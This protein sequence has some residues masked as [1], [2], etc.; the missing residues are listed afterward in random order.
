MSIIEEL[1]TIASSDTAGLYGLAE[2]ALSSSRR[3]LVLTLAEQ[4]FLSEALE[5][6]AK[7]PFINMIAAERVEI[8]K[9]LIQQEKYQQA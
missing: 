9:V 3:V 7:F 5:E 2:H 6:V 8:V 4:G 1:E